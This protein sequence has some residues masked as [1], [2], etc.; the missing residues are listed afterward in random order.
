MDPGFKHS[1][2][3]ERGLRTRPDLD[4]RSTAY[5]HDGDGS[6]SQVLQMHQGTPEG[7]DLHN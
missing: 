1:G 7:S 6:G 2:T 3:T 4:S 5:G